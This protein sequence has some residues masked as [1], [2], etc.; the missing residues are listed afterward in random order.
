MNRYTWLL[1]LTLALLLGTIATRAQ[2]E[3]PGRAFHGNTAFP[4]TGRHQT[5]A[6]ESCH[7][8]GVFKGTPTACYDCHWVRRQD[9]KFKTKLGTQCESCHRTISWA[10]VRWDHGAMTG[11][12]LNGGHRTL[13]CES[14]HT[15]T[16]FERAEVSCIACH[17]K[18]YDATKSP[19]H[20]AANFPTQCDACH[21]PSDIAFTQARF[22]HNAS[23]PLSGAHASIACATCHRAG[24]YQGTPRDCA[25]CHQNDFNQAKN[26]NHVAAGFPNQCELCHKPTQPTWTGGGTGAFNHSLYPLTGQHTTVSCASCHKNNVYLGTPRDCVGCHKPNY[27]RTTA[28]NHAQAGIPTTCENCHRPSDAT[29]KNGNFNHNS[30]FALVGKHAAAACASCHVNNVFKGTGRDCVDCHRPQYDR[31]T[32]P[33][34]AS[35][36]FSIQCASCHKPTD[37]SWSGVSF[38][39]NAFFQLQGKHAAAQCASCHVNG[40]YKGTGRNCVDCHLAKYN[41]T[42][43]PKHSTA[44]FS[45]QCDTCHKATDSQWTGV[46]FNHNAFFPL[47]GKHAAA[48]CATCHVNNVYKGTGRNCVDCHQAKY[49]ATTAPNHAS[50]GFSTQCDSCHKATDSQWTGITFNHNA[51]FPLQGKHT[52]AACAS[53]HVNNVYR[54]TS[55][56][57]VGCH[58]AKYNATSNPN[59]AASGFPT[60]CETCHLATDSAWTQGRFSHPD[61]P[62]TSGR[63]NVPCAQCHTSP[64]PAFNCLNCHLKAKTDGDHRGRSGYRYDSAA[65]YSCHPTGRAD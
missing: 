43:T 35:A 19:N 1:A 9:D 52:A 65:C 56:T 60:T 20:A 30:V 59:H 47:Q 40:V 48:Q 12:S 31:T 29:W 13:G 61:F 53:C 3:T 55:R 37:P 38:N 6:C 15:D 24:V 28:P 44:G 33:N 16:R 62:I 8:K 25:S 18:D 57:C 36:G 5:V 22:D 11:M 58:L 64:P 49:N 63:H 45:T 14:C 10:A 34:H 26:P 23:F 21:R 2:F 42:T 7:L 46:S 54:G 17:R 41:A 27:D 32:A 4:L 51:F 50:A 39:H